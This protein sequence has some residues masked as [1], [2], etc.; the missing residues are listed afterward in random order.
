MTVGSSDPGCKR[1]PSACLASLRVAVRTQRVHYLQLTVEYPADARH[2]MAEFLRSSDAVVREELL[3]WS[4]RPG[5]DVEFALFYVEG[6]LAA[7]RDAI[8][9][10]DS[11]REYTLT[12]VGDDDFYAF[13]CEETRDA[14]RRFRRAFADRD[15][16]VVP[17]IVY[18]NDG[19]MHLTVVGESEDLRAIVA[20]LPDGVDATV[21]GVG[22]FDR[23]HV[24]PAAELT[25]R[26]R[27]AVRVAVD[28]G[29]YDVPRDADLAGVAD[30]LDCASS[31]ASNLLRKAES[32]VMAGVVGR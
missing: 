7:Y 5:R 24:G 1:V 21:E 6:D 25:R 32:A 17:P 28:L 16:V 15:L 20:A 8:D 2:P 14:E 22:E 23:R 12:P 27:E 30:E 19:R 18:D 31:T 4:L 29:Y 3:A 13:V 9:D 26:Q 11:V 10:V